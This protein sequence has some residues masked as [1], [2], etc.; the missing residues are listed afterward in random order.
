MSLADDMMGEAFAPMMDL[1]GE[2]GVVYKKRT[3]VTRTISGMVDREAAEMP[4][5]GSVGYRPNVTL[6]VRDDAT[7]GIAGTEVDR[8]TDRIQ[9]PNGPGGQPQ[10]F[11]VANIISQNAGLITL[12]LV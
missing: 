5:G 9:L 6:T 2:P 4:A 10:W 11:S 12:H 7:V 8:G 3:G 1:F